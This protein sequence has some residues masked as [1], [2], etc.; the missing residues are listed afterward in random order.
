MDLLIIRGRLSNPSILPA[1]NVGYAEG[2]HNK[3]EIS[4]IH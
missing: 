1:F 4:K 2:V 3:N